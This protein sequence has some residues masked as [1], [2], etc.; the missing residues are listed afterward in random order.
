MMVGSRRK[1]KKELIPVARQMIIDKR[2]SL[3]VCQLWGSHSVLRGSRSWS[4]SKMASFV[5]TVEDGAP[6][7]GSSQSLPL[8]VDTWQAVNTPSITVPLEDMDILKL[9]VRSSSAIDMLAAC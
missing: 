1:L 3:D 8:S 6:P 7:R 5:L 2:P 9:R 4:T